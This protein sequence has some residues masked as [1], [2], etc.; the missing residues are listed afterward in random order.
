MPMSLTFSPVSSLNVSPSMID[1]QTRVSPTH[2][3]V[4]SVEVVSSV[5]IVFSVPGIVSSEEIVPGCCMQPT[6][7]HN[8]RKRRNIPPRYPIFLLCITSIPSL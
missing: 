1:V 6:I 3:I 4:S 5:K 2:V 8:K 7:A